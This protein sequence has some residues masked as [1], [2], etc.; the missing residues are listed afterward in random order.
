[1]TSLLSPSAFLFPHSILPGLTP[2]LSC[3]V[4]SFV[5]AM[6]FRRGQLSAGS[7][8]SRGRENEEKAF[9]RQTC[10]GNSLG[11]IWPLGPVGS[12]TCQGR[13]R[14]SEHKCEVL[15]DRCRLEQSE[16]SC[17]RQWEGWRSWGL[18]DSCVYHLLSDL[19]R[20]E[21][22]PPPRN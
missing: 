15:A 6:G 10:D 5:R 11:R 22:Q 14:Q 7:V 2:T 9:W 8:G 3:H 19:S 16:A 1:M 17:G 12:G 21:Q 20:P 4:S 13:D 18:V